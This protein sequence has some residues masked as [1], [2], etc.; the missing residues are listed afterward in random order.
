MEQDDTERVVGNFDL[1][2]ERVEQILPTVA[3]KDDLQTA[4]APLATRTE[5][6]AA[7]APLAN[8]AE[9]QAAVA[10]LANRAEL[11]AAID[12]AEGRMR[13]HFDVATE[14]LRD[15]IRLIAD[16][17][18]VLSQKVDQ[19]HGKLEANIAGLDLRLMRV[20]AAQSNH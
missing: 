4:V 6:Q 7:V 20:E 8:R 11:Q 5:L 2:V 15:D 1:R 13:T 12:G 10:P 16:G 14:S 9:L 18:A 19:N 17:L 3:T